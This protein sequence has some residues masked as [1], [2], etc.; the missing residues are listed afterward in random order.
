MPAI[1]PDIFSRKFSRRPAPDDPAVRAICQD[2]SPGY[3]PR[4]LPITPTPA[5]T[6]QECFFN[7]E[8]HAS[9]NGGSMLYGWAL[10]IWPEVFI[11]AEHH[12]VWDD[13]TQLHDI[14]PRADDEET[15][16]FLPDPSRTY[17]FLGNR[18]VDNQRRALS[19][20]REVRTLLNAYAERAAFFEMNSVGRKISIDPQEL[21]HIQNRVM[22]A[23]AH[24]LIALAASRG[25]NDPCICA[26]GR[27]FKKCCSPLIDLAA[28]E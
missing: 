1:H 24:V 11:E 18:R 6:P 12:A 2:L 27:K 9:S 23:S 20:S 15:T 25:R 8:Q 14:T 16:L 7:V 3:T 5:A 13:G 19:T 28:V 22:M 4:L 17:D 10:W 21:R 26:S